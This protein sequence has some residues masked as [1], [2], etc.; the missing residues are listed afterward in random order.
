MGS[1]GPI[2]WNSTVLLQYWQGKEAGGGIGFVLHKSG[3]ARHLVCGNWV[4]FAFF[5]PPQARRDGKLGSFR[6]N[7]G[8]ESR[9]D[10]SGTKNWVRFAEFG[11]ATGVN[12]VRFA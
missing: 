5:G 3:L 2:T 9:R 12:W 4:R 6:I 11:V 7:G 1:D 8:W 10:A